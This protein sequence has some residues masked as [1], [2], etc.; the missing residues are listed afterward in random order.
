ML[1]FLATVYE[2]L[3]RGDRAETTRAQKLSRYGVLWLLAIGYVLVRIR[4]LG[5]FAPSRDSRT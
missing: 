2:H 4:F 5:A 1:P 3:Y